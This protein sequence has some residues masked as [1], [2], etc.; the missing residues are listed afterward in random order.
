LH[1]ITTQVDCPPQLLGGSSNTN[2]FSNT[3]LTYTP[4]SASSG[5]G[6]ISSLSASEIELSED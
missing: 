3:N 5:N 6:F 1:N 2:N 4:M